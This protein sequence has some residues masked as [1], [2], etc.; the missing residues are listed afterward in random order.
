MVAQCFVV[1]L[2]P[3]ATT[4]TKHTCGALLLTLVPG[5]TSLTVALASHRVTAAISISTVACFCA[6][7]PPVACI[8]CFPAV[9]PSPA[10]SAGTPPAHSVTASVVLTDTLHLTPLTKTPTRTCVLTQSSHEP[11]RTDARPIML[12]ADAS[13]LTDW[14][15]L[16]AAGTPGPFWTQVLTVLS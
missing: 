10:G 2:T 12:I 1:T 11:W 16:C 15:G 3:M 9:V 6:V 7:C 13:V 14:T 4:K 8:A 5:V